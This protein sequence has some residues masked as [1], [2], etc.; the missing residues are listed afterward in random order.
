MS[1]NVELGAIYGMLF[2]IKFYWFVI[3][4][5]IKFAV[6]KNIYNFDGR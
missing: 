2:F 3:F 6:S 1:N 5:A 4:G